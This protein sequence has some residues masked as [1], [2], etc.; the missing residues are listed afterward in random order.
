VI[1]HVGQ[2]TTGSCSCC[3]TTSGLCTP[4]K[5]GPAISKTDCAVKYSKCSACVSG[6]SNGLSQCQFAS[7]SSAASSATAIDCTGPKQL[8]DEMAAFGIA[9]GLYITVLVIAAVLFCT[10]P[11]MVFACAWCC[12]ISSKKSKGLSI[13]GQQWCICMG[14]MIGICYGLGIFGAMIVPFAALAFWLGPCCMIIP[15]I[16]ES[17]CASTYTPR[18]PLSSAPS[19]RHPSLPKKILDSHNY[20]NLQIKALPNRLCS[21]KHRCTCRRR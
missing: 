8:C 19:L 1:Q 2:S 5:L 6:G 15:F 10:Y 21:C 9:A 7:S 16:Q 18:V 3:T 20:Q 11:C 12:C 17:C 13:S 4:V 14:V